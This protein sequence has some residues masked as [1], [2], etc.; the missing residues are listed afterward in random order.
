MTISG[1]GPDGKTPGAEL[2]RPKQSA[3]TARSPEPAVRAHGPTRGAAPHDEAPPQARSPP[4]ARHGQYRRSV[5]TPPPTGVQHHLVH[6]DQRATIT[7]VGASLREYAVGDRDVIVPFDVGGLPPASHGAVLI[8][9]PNRLR[10]GRYDWDGTTYQVPVTEPDRWTALHGLAAWE[11]WAPV[12]GVAARPDSITL[13]LDL[14]PIKGYPF[15]LRSTLTYTLS[16]AGLHVH[17]A[18]T[19][20]GDRVAPYGTGFHPWLSPG[21]AAVD[22]CTLRLD[23]ATRVTTDDRLLPTGT[24]PAGDLDFRTPRSLAGVALDDGYVDVTRDD[25]GLSWI[26]LSA[27]DGRTAAVWMDDSMDTWQVCTGDGIPGVNRNGVAAEP[28]TCIADAFRTGDRLVRLE[29]G[30]THEVVWGATLL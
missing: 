5:N 26:Q 13:G 30:Q 2:S 14:V 4:T 19:N 12:P 27:P 18:T 7:E 15:Q 20:I 23:A 8:P 25:D 22:E 17:L 16:V 11:R 3:I 1:V 10:D 9:W 28:M 21:G 29:P 24:E 6:G